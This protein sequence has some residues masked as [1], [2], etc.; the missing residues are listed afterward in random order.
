MG[1]NISQFDTVAEC[2][3]DKCSDFT[4]FY[5]NKQFKHRLQCKH[6]C[7]KVNEKI[8]EEVGSPNIILSAP[9]STNRCKNV[10]LGKAMAQAE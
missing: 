7:H 10:R 2:L 4:G 1:I 3:T 6:A 8:L 5:I 9:T